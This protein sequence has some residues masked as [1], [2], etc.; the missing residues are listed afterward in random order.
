MRY[1]IWKIPLSFKSAS[2]FFIG[3]AVRKSP[4][5]VWNRMLM[6]LAFDVINL[7]DIQA[8]LSALHFD[9]HIIFLLFLRSPF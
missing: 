9:R 7:T 6:A 3:P 2:T 5:S 4:F 8:H 1:G